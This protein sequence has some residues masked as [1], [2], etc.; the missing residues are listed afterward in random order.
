MDRRVRFNQTINGSDITID[1]GS[2]DANGTN[3]T[4]GP[5]AT[6]EDSLSMFTFETNGASFTVPAGKTVA[7]RITNS[8]TSAVS[9]RQG[10]FSYISAPGG[11]NQAWP[12]VLAGDIV[13]PK[14]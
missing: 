4:A 13:D 2:A 11:T 9:V 1:I 10:A 8:H 12:G 14:V 5:Q 3:F 7:M 6:L